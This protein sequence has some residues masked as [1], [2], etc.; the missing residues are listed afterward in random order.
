MAF[1]SLGFVLYQ[2]SPSDPAPTQLPTCLPT[3]ATGGALSGLLIQQGVSGSPLTQAELKHTG[4]CWAW[5]LL[6]SAS[7]LAVSFSHGP[8]FALWALAVGLALSYRNWDW[9]LSICLPP[10]YTL[11]CLVLSHGQLIKSASQGANSPVI[12]VSD[13]LPPCTLA[14]SCSW[15]AAGRRGLSL[16]DRPPACGLALVQLSGSSHLYLRPPALTESLKVVFLP[17][18]ENL[19]HFFRF[20]GGVSERATRPEGRNS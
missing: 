12:S 7:A 13:V 19:T 17:S 18:A 3:S 5:C 6:F 11:A 15:W 1:L 2:G 14:S 20:G 10:T 8:W 4:P 9:V 16:R